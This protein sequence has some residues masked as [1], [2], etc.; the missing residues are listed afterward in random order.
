M[1]PRGFP[2]T[3]VPD[4]PDHHDLD[5]KRVAIL[6]AGGPAPAANAVIST[7]AFS[8]LEEGA[9]VFGIKHGYSRLAEYTAAGPLQEGSD[10]I[11]FTHERLTHARTS[12][13]IMIGTARTNPGKHV[14]A[15]E[16]LKDPELVAPL[17]RVYEGLC[18]LEVD[19][20]ISI[21]GD[22]TLKTANKLKM[23]QDNLPADAR[24]F[25]V[26]HLP[27]T[28]DNDYTGI[29][30]TFGF[31]TAVETLAEEIRNLNYDA[32][33]GRAY[34]LCEAMGRSAGWLAYG[35]AIA[36]EAS[37][38]LSV[39]DIIGPLADE[40]F[41]SASNTTRKV[42]NLDKV[43]DR[44]VDMMVA[45]EREGRDYGTIVIAEGVAEFLS[46]KHLEGIS[47]D[48]HGHINISSINL[49]ALIASSLSKR[50]AE[51]T[52]RSRKINGVQLGYEARC[53]PPQAYDVILGSQLG[54]G[55]YRALV[56]EKLNGVMVS[57]SGQFDLHFVPFEHLVDPKTLVTKVRRIETG[58][59]FHRLAR[60][61]E[62]CIDN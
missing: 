28:I 46:L 4:M 5:I 3:F 58:S 49:S 33:A 48:D 31:F 11:R 61:L 20:L 35:A 1:P 24:R 29:D 55:A 60:F 39:E 51:R 19:A 52:G 10:Y 57:V 41:D 13:G 7:A 15:P 8:F 38:V 54:V 14:S 43:I 50:Y 32:A 17:R 23:F 18:S 40:E 44:M 36:G 27:K 9:Q 47:R 42:M 6:F 30:F 53:A 12:R 34:F 59:D 45:R 16:H 62:T 56:E 22:D 25:P 26:V 21:G 37:M 2:P